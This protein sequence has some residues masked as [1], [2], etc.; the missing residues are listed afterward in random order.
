[1]AWRI[2]AFRDI[3]DFKREMDQMLRE[4]RETPIA[5]N[6]PGPVIV[7]GDPEIEAERRNRAEGVPV[8]AGLVIELRQ[9][10]EDLKIKHPFGKA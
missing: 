6:A 1:M 9:L 7:P 2:D 8:A 10:A 4:F 3:D 5:D